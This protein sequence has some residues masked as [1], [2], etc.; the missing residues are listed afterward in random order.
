ML[1]SMVLQSP[2]GQLHLR[3]PTLMEAFR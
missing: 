1:H 2:A 3:T